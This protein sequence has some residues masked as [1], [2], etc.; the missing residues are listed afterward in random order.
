M[1]CVWRTPDYDWVSGCEFSQTCE[2]G[3]CPASISFVMNFGI[4]YIRLSRRYTTHTHTMDWMHWPHGLHIVH[5]SRE[6]DCRSTI[7]GERVCSSQFLFFLR[8]RLRSSIHSFLPH[9]LWSQWPQKVIVINVEVE[10]ELFADARNV[11]WV[12]LC[13]LLA[14]RPTQTHTHTCFRSS[15]FIILDV[16]IGWWGRLRALARANKQLVSGDLSHSSIF[17]FMWMYLRAR[18][19]ADDACLP[20]NCFQP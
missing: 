13:L 19:F 18:R 7:M 20:A 9:T 11:M 12:F 1:L 17:R 15:L 5:R 10:I 2:C 14:K 3:K 16:R 4:G 8:C 6:H